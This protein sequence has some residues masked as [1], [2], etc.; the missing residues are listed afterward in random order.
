MWRGESETHSPG[1]KRK[2][3]GA[4]AGERADREIVEVIGLTSAGKEESGKRAAVNH[5][6][7]HFRINRI[8]LPKQVS[9]VRPIG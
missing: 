2:S 4:D 3:P 9:N 5:T 7:P 1:R 8:W 6:G